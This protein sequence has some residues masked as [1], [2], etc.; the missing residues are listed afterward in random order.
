MEYE[1]LIPYSQEP[2]EAKI[3]CQMNPVQNL[4]SLVVL[5]KKVKL[6]P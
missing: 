1:D 6:S 5:K 4:T 3:L 2:V